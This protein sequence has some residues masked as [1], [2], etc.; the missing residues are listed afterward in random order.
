[1]HPRK[2]VT[3]PRSR[4]LTNF[5]EHLL[6]AITLGAQ[7]SKITTIE[8]TRIKRNVADCAIPL[9]GASSQLDGC[10]YPRSIEYSDTECTSASAC[11]GVSN[12]RV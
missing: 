7:K 3:V 1:M 4:K 11:S 2:T 5:A 9:V 8:V 10:A 6:K 12:R